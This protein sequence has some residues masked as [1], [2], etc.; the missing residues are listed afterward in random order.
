MDNL[1]GNNQERRKYKTIHNIYN[2]ITILFEMAKLLQFLGSYGTIYL[3]RRK[4]K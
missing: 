2:N 1:D 3:L 4:H